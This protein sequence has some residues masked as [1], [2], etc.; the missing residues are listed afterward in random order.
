MWRAMSVLAAFTFVGICA[1]EC[2]THR[3]APVAASEKPIRHLGMDDPMPKFDA[4]FEWT[5]PED[6]TRRD[7]EN[8]FYLWQGKEVG[9]GLRGFMRIL[10]NIALLPE[11]SVILA[12]PAGWYR[13]TLGQS[14]GDC[15][16]F[17]E[18][19]DELADVVVRRH[20][21]LVFSARDHLGRITPEFAFEWHFR[22]AD[23]EEGVRF[24]AYFTWKDYDGTGDAERA[25]FIWQGRELGKGSEGFGRVIEELGR[26]RPGSRV[27]VFPEYAVRNKNEQRWQPFRMYS[28]KLWKKFKD[29]LIANNLIVLDSYCDQNGKIHPANAAYVKK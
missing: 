9:G 14:P 24:D 17:D 7:P 13:T 22:Q 25:I 18:Y 12:Y 29:T 15:Y 19:W 1:C 8:A 2:K 27:L 26:L 21:I 28:E 10:V 20:H 3:E 16:P 23:W 11:R 6:P 4:Y 5:E